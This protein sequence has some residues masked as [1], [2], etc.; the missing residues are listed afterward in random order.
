MTF[1]AWWSERD[2]SFFRVVL[3]ADAPCPPSHA[4]HKPR[5]RAPVAAASSDMV[6]N[7]VVK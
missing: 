2:G 3:Y 5:R 6:L 4:P 7:T 1:T